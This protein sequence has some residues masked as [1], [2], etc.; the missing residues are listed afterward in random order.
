MES[1]SIAARDRVE[2]VREE[3]MPRPEDPRTLAAIKLVKVGQSLRSA[4]KTM[5]IERTTLQ[6]ALARRRVVSEE[7]PKKT[8]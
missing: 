1:A 5:G 6:R 8:D 3:K 4:A 2:N 7:N